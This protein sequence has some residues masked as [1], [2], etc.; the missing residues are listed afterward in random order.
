MIQN[1]HE[2]NDIEKW[3]EGSKQNIEKFELVYDFF[4][5]QI[6]KYV[7]SR[8]GKKDFTTQIV[9]DI[10]YKAMTKIHQYKNNGNSFKAWLYKIAQN[11]ILLFYRK[12]KTSQ[13]YLID[14]N[15]LAEIGNET[16]F[17]LRD[18]YTLIKKAFDNLSDIEMEMIEMKYFDGYSHEQIAEIMDISLSSSKTKIHRI[19]KKLQLIFLNV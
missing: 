2:I 1:E 17:E 13:I 6:Y 11:E 9:S 7:Y 8:V 16:Q 5:V 10:F 4:Y 12:N 19:I 3:V 15:F 14:S 18:N